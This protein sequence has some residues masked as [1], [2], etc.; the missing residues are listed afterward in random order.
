MDIILF[1]LSHTDTHSPPTSPYVVPYHIGPFPSSQRHTPSVPS[2]YSRTVATVLRS[3]TLFS[4]TSSGLE[5]VL[6]PPT[7]A[8]MMSHALWTRINPVKHRKT[9]SIQQLVLSFFA[10]RSHSRHYPEPCSCS[11]QPLSLP[12]CVTACVCRHH[13]RIDWQS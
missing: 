3:S 1:K 12:A 9:T 8:Y 13:G 5:S 10:P 6:A 2:S 4:V 7:T 11:N